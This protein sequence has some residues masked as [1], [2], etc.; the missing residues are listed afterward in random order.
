MLGIVQT[1][2]RMEFLHGTSENMGVSFRAVDSLRR[3]KIWFSFPSK[4]KHKKTSFEHKPLT[5]L[6]KKGHAL[7][8]K[9]Y[10]FGQELHLRVSTNH[11]KIWSKITKGSILRRINSY[12]HFIDCY[13]LSYYIANLI[14]SCLC[15][16]L[17]GCMLESNHE[18]FAHVCEFQYYNYLELSSEENFQSCFLFR[19]YCF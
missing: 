12:Y 2:M 19:K 4:S 16:V 5:Y 8:N 9:N 7:K 6:S 15:R 10:V 18:L 3:C 14:Y 1:D 11:F 13:K 17:R